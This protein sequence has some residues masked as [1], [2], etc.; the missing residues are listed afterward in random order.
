MPIEIVRFF[1]LGRPPEAVF[2][3][4]RCVAIVEETLVQ[5]A[6][7][8]LPLSTRFL[9]AGYVGPRKSARAIVA[10]NEI[11]DKIWYERCILFT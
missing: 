3:S 5:A 8:R 6:V 1:K 4:W 10:P 9:G 7:T 11:T 2:G